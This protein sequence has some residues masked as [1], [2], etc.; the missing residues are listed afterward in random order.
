MTINKSEGLQCLLNM[1]KQ[2]ILDET[3]KDVKVEVITD[4][5][6]LGSISKTILVNGK[7]VAKA[8]VDS[9]YPVNELEVQNHLYWSFIASLCMQ[10]PS[11]PEGDLYCIKDI[12]EKL[13]K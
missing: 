5:K 8:S 7:K 1:I 6:S 4:N 10:A 9:I 11:V 3:G 12:I 13:K 2:S